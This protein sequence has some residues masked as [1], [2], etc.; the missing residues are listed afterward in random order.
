MHIYLPILK[1]GLFVFFV[2]KLH[3]WKPVENIKWL[4][5]GEI[6]KPTFYRR[7]IVFKKNSSTKAV[8][9][10]GLSKSSRC[11][12]VPNLFLNK[13]FFLKTFS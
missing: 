1:S 2:K 3:N 7:E 9:G 6:I 11:D 8:K 10:H 5:S 13:T 4:P 12:F